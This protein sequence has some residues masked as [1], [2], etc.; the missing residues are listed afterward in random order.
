MKWVDW[1]LYYITYPNQDVISTKELN[2]HI[3]DNEFKFSSESKK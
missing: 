2:I 3:Y 1:W